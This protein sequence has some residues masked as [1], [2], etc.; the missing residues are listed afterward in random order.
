MMCGLFATREASDD[1]A[2]TD[3]ILELA[4]FVG[5]R[6]THDVATLVGTGER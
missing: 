3:W 2:L 5:R 4:L 6:Q 1:I